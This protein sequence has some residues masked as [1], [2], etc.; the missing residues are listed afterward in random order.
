MHCHR[1]FV[2]FGVEVAFNRNGSG[3]VEYLYSGFGNANYFNNTVA[4][5]KVDLSTVKVG[6][7]YRFN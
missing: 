5:G 7:N 3:K 1:N 4:S 2:I 6:L